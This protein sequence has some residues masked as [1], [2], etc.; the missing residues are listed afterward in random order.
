MFT[1]LEEGIL[2]ETKTDIAMAAA[3]FIPRLKSEIGQDAVI[4]LRDMVLSSTAHIFYHND[5]QVTDFEPNKSYQNG[6]HAQVTVPAK[7]KVEYEARLALAEISVP[8]KV[9]VHQLFYHASTGGT[10]AGDHVLSHIYQPSW[11][12]IEDGKLVE[13]IACRPELPVHN[14]ARKHC[15]AAFRCEEH[16]EQPQ[17]PAK[18]GL[19]T[20]VAGAITNDPCLFLNLS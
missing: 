13:T 6:G 1:S 19:C 20:C 5:V 12:E 10:L 14:E 15:A 11:Y 18:R 16:P 8:A 9:L 3:Q 17:M 7:W 4:D 2:E